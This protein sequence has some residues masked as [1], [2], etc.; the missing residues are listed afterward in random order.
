MSSK[1]KKEDSKKIS[2]GKELPFKSGS[3]LLRTFCWCLYRKGVAIH[4][5]PVLLFLGVSVSLIFFF[6]WI[7]LVSWRIFCSFTGILRVRR[8]REIL[9]VFGPH[10]QYGWDFPEEIPEKFRK[11]PGDALRA[12]PGISLESTAGMPQAL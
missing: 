4:A 2:S 12:F 5:Y 1:K 10:P 6:R 3:K 7:S 8:V 11:D 9:D